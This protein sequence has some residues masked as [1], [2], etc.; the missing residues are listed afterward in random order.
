MVRF[1]TSIEGRRNMIAGRLVI[2]YEEKR[3]KKDDSRFWPEQLSQDE[4]FLESRA[5]TE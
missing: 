4:S 5:W 2:K 3:A 1:R